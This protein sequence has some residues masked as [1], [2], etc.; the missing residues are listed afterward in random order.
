MFN[1]ISVIIPIY[2]LLHNIDDVVASIVFQ[3]YPIPMEIIIVD[4]GSEVLFKS[5]Y[6]QR[7]KIIYLKKENGGAASARNYGVL[8]SKFELICFLDA[9]DIW[10]KEKIERQYKILIENSLE[11]LGGGWN[12]RI[13]PF[14]SNKL[15]LISFKLLPMKWWPHISTVMITKNLFNKVGGF[16]EKFSHGEDGDF[17][18][19]IAKL[20]KLYVYQENFANTDINK[21]YPFESGLSSSQEKMLKGELKIINRYF[22][23]IFLITF[24]TFLIVLKYLFRKIWI[25]YQRIKYLN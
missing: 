24:Y 15:G 14:I 6:F 5:D 13:Y 23:N 20:K 12:Q 21:M 9:D 7:K 11:F 19:K 16:D 17:L 18:M 10:A 2:N 4:D 25:C 22:N 3:D 8:Y 1:G